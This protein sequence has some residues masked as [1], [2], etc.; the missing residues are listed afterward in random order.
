[1]TEHLVLIPHE[2]GHG[3]RHLLVMQASWLLHSALMEHSGLQFGG[4]PMNVAKQEH[5]GDVPIA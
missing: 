2:P 1:M 3:S 5:D 4:L